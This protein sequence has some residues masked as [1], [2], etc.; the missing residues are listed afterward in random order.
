MV[1][2]RSKSKAAAEASSSTS[3]GTSSGPDISQLMCCVCQELPRLG[4][5]K[6][7]KCCTNGHILCTT[8]DKSMENASNSISSL[9]CPLCRDPLTKTIPGSLIS[10]LVASSGHVLT[11]L[12]KCGVTGS[13]LSL[14]EHEA[15]CKKGM[16]QCSFELCKK[17]V[18]MKNLPVHQRTCSFRPAR[19]HL[20]S[21]SFQPSDWLTAHPGCFSSTD[22]ITLNL[23]HQPF[24]VLLGMGNN[25]PLA[26]AMIKRRFDEQTVRIEVFGKQSLDTQKYK[27]EVVLVQEEGGNEDVRVNATLP[28][29]QWDRFMEINDGRYLTARLVIRIPRNNDISELTIKLVS[30]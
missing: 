12:Y 22:R 26:F 5:T 15:V 30:N 19:C 27:A 29:S 7:V 28:V 4:E 24:L 9:A 11:C 6:E 14:G 1:Q 3:S 16:V 20:C 10:R 2:T 23:H 18:R 8:C 17:M 13:L 21:N 25:S